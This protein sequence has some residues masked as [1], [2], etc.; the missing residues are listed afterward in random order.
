MTAPEH[1][2]ETNR[3]EALFS[4]GLL[5]TPP[6]GTFD[7]VTRLA[8]RHFKAPIASVSLVDHDR[9]WFLS[10][11]GMDAVETTRDPG[12]CASVILSDEA[13]VVRDA[14]HDP[15]TL[16][17]PLVRGELGLRFYAAVPLTTHDGYRL[18]T[19]NVIDFEP[20]DFDAADEDALRDFA[21]IVMEQMELRL[22]SRKIVASLTAVFRASKDPE[23]LVTVCAWTKKINVGGQWM[24]FDDFLVKT[25][26]FSTTHSIHPDAMNEVLDKDKP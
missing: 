13:Y 20:R 14:L 4:Y 9:I 1:E 3:L 7:R 24:S 21:G 23:N 5:D 19:M 17:N 18:G 6:D 12:L 2:Q 11:A 8:A 22:A 26:G 16:E 10:K 15:R 25:L